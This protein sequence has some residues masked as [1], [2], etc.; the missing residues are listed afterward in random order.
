MLRQSMEDYRQALASASSIASLDQALRLGEISTFEY[1]MEMSFY[2]NA[3][4][5]VLKTE[6]DYQVAVAELMQFLL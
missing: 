2:Q 4:L 3:L 6:W 1:F 5:H